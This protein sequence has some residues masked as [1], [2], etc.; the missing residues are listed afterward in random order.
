MFG[1]NAGFAHA[2]QGFC[3]RQNKFAAGVVLEGFHPRQV[4]VDVV[5][6]HDIPEA[7]DF[8]VK[9]GLIGVHR[10]LEVIVENHDVTFVNVRGGFNGNGHDVS[11][12]SLLLGGTDTLALS[13]HV[14]FEGFLQFWEMV[15]DVLDVDQRPRVVVA[16]HY[17]LDP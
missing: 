2:F 13:A 3:L 8:R 4:A 16:P 5:E 1:D 10:G 12:P 17:G 14:A 7:R 6:N 11:I 15:G 9:A